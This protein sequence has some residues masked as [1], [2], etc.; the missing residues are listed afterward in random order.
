MLTMECIATIG[1]DGF[2][3][4]VKWLLYAGTKKPPVCFSNLSTAVQTLTETGR[5]LLIYIH[6]AGKFSFHQFR[7]LIPDYTEIK[8]I[9]DKIASFKIGEIEFRDSS[10]ILP[11]EI[12]NNNPE[13]PALIPLFRLIADFE[14]IAGRHLTIS[15]AGRADWRKLARR[16]MPQ[17]TRLYY[18][19][20]R[21]FYHGGRTEAY[22]TG[23]LKGKWEIY[24][25][26]SAYPAAMMFYHPIGTHPITVHDRAEIIDALYCP[27][28]MPFMLSITAEPKGAFPVALWTGGRKSLYFPRDGKPHDFQI[29]SHELIAALELEIYELEE[30]SFNYAIVFDEYTTF[31]TYVK[32]WGAIKIKARKEKQLGIEITAKL[33]LNSLYGG[34]A[35]NPDNFRDYIVAP[36]IEQGGLLAEGWTAK[37]GG[38]GDYRCI[39]ERQP[40]TVNRHINV[41]TSASITGQVRADMLRAIHGADEVAYCDTD[42]IFC[43]APGNLKIGAETGEWKLEGVADKLTIAAPK[44]Y[45]A[46]LTTGKTKMA[47]KGVN[48]TAAEITRIARGGR[49]THELQHQSQGITG[50]PYYITRKIGKK[51]LQLRK[52]AVK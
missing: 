33:M 44:M 5:S 45:A 47:S 43:R 2:M 27:K 20:L 46:K 38:F 51:A 24:D 49:V 31:Q 3:Q 13:I 42:S 12:P 1:D 15:G 40:D 22:Q 37:Q 25:I 41:A 6:N 21:E 28:S 11:V 35:I 18:K 14:S 4:P 34:F 10:L 23:E 48:L 19:Q 8:I 16:R 30:I 52:K 29:T 26:N 50:K 7:D 17:S 9:K 39:Y 36:T 32:K